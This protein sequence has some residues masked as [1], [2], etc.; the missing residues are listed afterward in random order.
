MADFHRRDSFLRNTDTFQGFLDI[1]SLPTIP[2]SVDDDIYIIDSRYH[3][4]PDLLASKLYETSEL[5]WVFATRNPDI[6]VD[7]IRDFKTG[8]TIALPSAESVIRA[9]GG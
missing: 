2:K 8:V 5:W 4:R 9:T 3:E 7:P 6:I 1:N